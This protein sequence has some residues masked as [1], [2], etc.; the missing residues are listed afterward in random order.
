M[1]Q[2]PLTPLMERL[3]QAEA[4][5]G[6]AAPVAA[7]LRRVTS[8][9]PLKAALRGDWLGHA[10]HPLLTD[11]VITCFLGANLADLVSP[12]DDTVAR[13]L[14][15]LGIAAYVPTALTGGSDW[16]DAEPREPGVRRTGLV[17]AAANAGGL[18]LYA[19]SWRARR[20]GGRAR[21][22]ALALAGAGALGAGAYLGGHLAYVQGVCVS[23]A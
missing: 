2:S 7:Q 22:R 9:P 1:S 17:H 18:A 6:I 11:A 8:P 23:R 3:E 12:H 14:I 16:S 15:G 20:R 13:R 10:V 4:L 5:D 19:A 21:G